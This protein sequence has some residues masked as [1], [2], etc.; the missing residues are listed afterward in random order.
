[1]T[2]TQ[3]IIKMLIQQLEAIMA[4][5]SD[6]TDWTAAFLQWRRLKEMDTGN[7]SRN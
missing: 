2:A 3:I 4:I 1:M 7:D 5:A 6:D